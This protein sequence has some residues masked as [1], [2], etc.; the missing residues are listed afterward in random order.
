[1]DFGENVIYVEIEKD[2]KKALS[3]SLV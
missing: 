1:L 3:E 2:C